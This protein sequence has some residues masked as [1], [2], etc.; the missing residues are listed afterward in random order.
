L[1]GLPHLELCTQLGQP[2]SQ[3]HWAIRERTSAAHP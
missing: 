1:F 2:L 3:G